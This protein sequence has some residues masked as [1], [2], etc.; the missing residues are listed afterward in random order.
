MN[1]YLQA[2]RLYRNMLPDVSDEERA[3]AVEQDLS[4]QTPIEKS[5]FGSNVP[6][7]LD[8]QVYFRM[9]SY[10]LLVLII[11]ATSTVMM[12]FNRAD[13]KMRNLCSRCV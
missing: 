4:Q 5:T 9:L 2:D 13:L 12:V 11:L 10:I 6:V 1:Q 3:A 8:V 7:P